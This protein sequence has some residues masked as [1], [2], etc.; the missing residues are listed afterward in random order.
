MVH[1]PMSLN[2]GSSNPL[3]GHIP[4]PSSMGTSA[5]S[6][7]LVPSR[8]SDD[9]VTGGGSDRILVLDGQTNQALACVR[10]LGKAGYEVNVASHQ[11]MPLSAWSRYCS[12]SFHLKG[13][14]IEAFAELRAWA[15]SAGVTLVLP[16]TERSCLLCNAN[17]S[18]WEDAGITLGCAPDEILQAAFDK[19]ITVRRAQALGVNTPR[20]LIPEC[21]KDVISAIEQIGFPCVIKPRW[22]NAWNGKEFLPTQSPAYASD[23]RQLVQLLSTHN[24]ETSWPLLQSFVP[25][26][27]KGVFALCNRGTVVA[28]FAHERLRDTKP[29]GSSSSLRR[30]IALDER[31]LEPARKLLA[32]FE[33]HGPAMVEFRDTGIN[34]PSLMEVN[35]RFWGSLQ[36]AIDSGVDFPALWVSILKGEAVEPVGDFKVGQTL[37]WLSG[38]LKRLF[39]ILRGAPT[40]YVGDFPSVSQ[41]LKEVFGRQP[42]GTRLE[43]LRANDPLPA[44]GELIGGIRDLVRWR[45]SSDAP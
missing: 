38:D 35:G 17:R 42:A 11:R 13:Q 20:T 36:L 33:W 37:R 27:G 15:I 16:L 6:T 18:E 40:G 19:A 44:L 14:T 9:K 34:P 12:S 26:R 43:V 29:T 22:S 25:G 8:S 3:L 39:F 21:L 10:S 5:P 28:W 30:S 4:T 31:L 32:D 2:G 45:D 7:R 24:G 1:T 23:R 41:G